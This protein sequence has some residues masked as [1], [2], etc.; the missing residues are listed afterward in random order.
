MSNIHNI[1][2]QLLQK[3]NPIIIEVGAHYGEDS[4]KFLNTF[5]DLKL[6]CFEPDPR[7][8]TVIK[9]Y[10]KD[11]RLHLFEY[12][13]FNQ[14]F[15]VLPFYQSYE[16]KV[17]EFLFK[18]YAWIKRTDYIKW[19]LNRSGASSLK[20]GHIFVKDAPKIYVKTKRLDTWLT[21]QQILAVDLIW[22]DVQGAEKEVIEG[23]GKYKDNI[24]YL[25]TEYGETTYE[26]GL[27][28]KQTIILLQKLNFGLIS[29]YS[30][31][32]PQGNLLFKN[33][34]YE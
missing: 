15:S 25:W 30:D 33:K 1:F 29:K 19:R 2:K 18:K 31:K 6:Y 10:I 3:E 27:N 24:K 22:I 4:I 5:K 7:N 13:L 14:D 11:T 21:E 9:N 8:I 12:A 17:K 23:F 16:S 26:G 20:Q 28:R 32:T 34:K